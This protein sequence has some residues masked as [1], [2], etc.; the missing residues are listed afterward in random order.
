[1]ARLE[2]TRRAGRGAAALAAAAAGIAAAAAGA[3]RAEADGATVVL[4]PISV[5]ATRNPVE[6]FEYPGMVTV[7]GR[8]ELQERQA[9]TPD[10]ILRFLPNVEFVGGPRRTGEVPNIRG[11]EGPD[12]VVLFDGARQN[13][14]STHDGRFFVDPSLLK[15]VEVLRGPASA[16]YGSG[17]TGGVIEFRTLDAADFLDEG[18]RSGASVSVGARTVNGER[19]GVFTAFGRPAETVDL[20]GSVTRR[21]SGAIALGN[22]STLRD[23]DDDILAGLAKAGFDLGADHRFEAAFMRFGNEAR[24]PNI[25]GGPDRGSAAATGGGGIVDKDISSDTVRASWRYDDPDD[26]LFDVDAVAY[27]AAVSVDETRR[28]DTGFTGL[29]PAGEALS[30]EIVTT[31][32]RLDNRSRARFARGAEAVF[33]WGGEFYRDVQDGSGGEGAHSGAPPGERDG[34]PD[35]ES[36]FLGVFAQGEFRLSEPLGVLPGTALLVPGVRFDRYESASAVAADND[37]REFSPRMGASWS[38]SDRFMLFGNYAHAFR[39]PTFNELYLDGFHFAI[40]LREPVCAV[41]GGREVCFPEG[42]TIYNKFAANPDLR[43][44]RTRTLEFGG[45]LTFDG[46]AAAG[47]RLEVKASVFR[48]TGKDFIDRAVYQPAPFAECFPYDVAGPPAGVGGAPPAGPGGPP[49]GVGGPPAGV[50]GP[51]AG[52]GGPPAFRFAPGKCDGSTTAFNRPHVRLRGAE[53]EARYESARF[54]VSLGYS[55]V[56]GE[57]RDTGETLGSLTPDMFTVAASVRLPELDAAAG[58]RALMARAFDK[59][60]AADEAE[61]RRMARPGYTVHDVHFTWAPT[62]GALEGL[63]IDLG[64]DNVFDKAYSRVWTGA[65]EAG[66]DFKAQVGYALAW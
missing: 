66:R 39:A 4:P 51:P 34:V 44:Q 60:S 63:R 38:P 24:E 35:A 61:R 6:A 3:A 23:T 9:S 32:M 27:R 14:G 20:V 13:F 11:F 7:V 22:G 49:A 36:E 30:R 18:E 8:R 65:F 33:T 21:A 62:A 41:Q 45:G 17:G 48:A 40:P 47:D 58:W 55:R 52:A 29:A 19:A 59:F 42:G 5:T 64:V 56:D 37:A 28:D 31:G 12:V 15:R 46:L 26:A 1:M 25:G 50:G 54:R 16:L 57:D 53:A 10:D 43:P 2:E